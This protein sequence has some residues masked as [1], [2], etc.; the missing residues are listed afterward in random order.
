MNIAIIIVGH[1]RNS[2]KDDG[3]KI[4]LN[5]FKE[6]FDI[7]D[8]FMH[9]W[10]TY[11][12]CTSSPLQTNYDN[13]LKIKMVEEDDI[14]NYLNPTEHIIEEQN[15]NIIIG[16]KKKKFKLL[17]IPCVNIKYIYYALTKACE[18]ALNHQQKKNIKYNFLVKIRPDIKKFNKIFILDDMSKIVNKMKHYKDKKKYM[19]S[20]LN[21][22]GRVLSDNFYFMNFED[23]HVF[24]MMMYY[25]F[26]KLNTMCVIPENVLYNCCNILK[27]KRYCILKNYNKN[28]SLYLKDNKMVKNAYINII[29][30]MKQ[31]YAK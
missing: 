20:F 18:L 17:G 27:Y 4:L 23:S 7:C 22:P 6:N 25:D 28:I 5:I 29:N 15:S 30:N 9:T 31:Y 19:V 16:N 3:L 10:T 11:E 1:I 8:I 14:K 2:F 21:K 13:N 12:A 24:F 26:D